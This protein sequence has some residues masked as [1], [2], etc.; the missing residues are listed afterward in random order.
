MKKISIFLASLL[1]LATTAFMP[2]Y[3]QEEAPNRLLLVNNNGNFSGYNIEWLDNL[4]FKTVEG[5][6][7]AEVK[8]LSLDGLDKIDLSVTMSEACKY[9]RLAMVTEFQGSRMNDLSVISYV[10]SYGTEPYEESFERATLSGVNLKPGTGYMLMTVGYDE[11]DTAVG[12]SRDF[13]STPDVE[14]V[15]DPYVEWEIEEVTMTSISV[16]FYPNDDVLEYFP[17]LFE[18]GEWEEF[19]AM[20]G[21]SFGFTTISELIEFWYMGR[22]GYDDAL[23]IEW[24][25]DI[26]P[27]TT[28]EILIAVKDRNGN[29][30]PH[31]TITVKTDSKGGSGD[32]YVDIEIGPFTPEIWYGELRPSQYIT[33]TPNEQTERYRFAVYYDYEYERFGYELVEELMQE[34]PQPG[35]AY[36][37]FYD[38]VTTDYPIDPSTTCYAIAVAQNADGVWGEPNI[39]EF[40]TPDECPGW[41]PSSLPASPEAGEKGKIASR[42]IKKEFDLAGKS[43]GMKAIRIVDAPKAVVKQ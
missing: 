33:Y 18:D 8:F 17:M 35:M 20:W 3:A 29:F 16:A 41:N 30:T 40:T 6:V 26:A 13:F 42:E 27:G 1:T 7:V 19:L 22:P 21:P 39:L 38:P 5:D 43:K 10:D 36:W 2:A 24:D 25:E 12:V 32:A 31:E 9:F 28:Y 34:P 15:G 4:E 37:W 23:I 14:I 11:Y